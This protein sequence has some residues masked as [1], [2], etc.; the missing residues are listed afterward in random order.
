[1][2][3][4][5]PLTE[6]LEPGEYRVQWTIPSREG[7]EVTLEGDLELTADRPPRA[8]AYGDLPGTYTYTD[9]TRSAGFPQHYDGGQIRGR[10]LNGR[11]VL[12]IDTDIVVWPERVTLQAR[13][14]L[15]GRLPAPAGDLQVVRIDV[16]IDALDAIA[17]I[18]PLKDLFLPKPPA[19]SAYLDWTWQVTGQPDS[20]QKWADDH[21]DI[22]LRFLNSYSGSDWF[23]YR[24]NFSPVVQIRLTDPIDFDDVFTDWIE[25]LR[26]IV[27]VSTDRQ[28][29]LTYLELH[30]RNGEETEEWQVYG[31]GL[32]QDPYASLGNTVTK[33]KTAFWVSPQD[34]SLLDLL[35]RW[36]SLAA[37]HHP[38]L[39][40][41]GS[42][43]YAP[44]RHPRSR[45]LLLL[46]AIEGL[47][48]YETRQDYEGR[49]A[50]HLARRTAI[51]SQLAPSTDPATFR[52]L[53]K[54]LMKKPPTGLQAAISSV[55]NAAPI[56]VSADLA[57]SRLLTDHSDIAL[58]LSAIRNDLAHGNRGYDADDLHEIVKPL[59]GVVR[60]HLLRVL[61]CSAE[62]Q[63]RA[64][65][66]D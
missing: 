28:E 13:A 10:L 20:T 9:G 27:S 45:L 66:L 50:E 22:E 43:I 33:T 52:F 46:Q 23:A 14:A 24:I 1:M 59:E 19:G 39:E 37:D 51:L 31:H 55:L 32:H 15:I 34:E 8:H 63:K 3:N 36:Q 47:H 6:V 11:Y 58:R 40:T 12:L 4:R 60:A 21:A 42:L 2:R 30:V 56:D 65:Q 48:G 61:G 41:Y 17:G 49:L 5:V 29:R 35:R 44:D 62:A 38:L 7:G 18:P 64:Q 53:K 57:R 54:H 16:Q 26:R 25:P